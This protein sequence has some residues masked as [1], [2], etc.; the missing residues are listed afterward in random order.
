MILFQFW[1][2]NVS[3]LEILAVTTILVKVSFHSNSM[4][5]NVQRAIQLHS[6]HMLVVLCSKSF[7]LGFSSV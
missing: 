6:F 3:K 1:I 5:K 2:Q 4:L 7:K